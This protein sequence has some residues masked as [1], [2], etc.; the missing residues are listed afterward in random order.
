MARF[1]FCRYIS[2]TQLCSV[3][4]LVKLT[5][6]LQKINSSY[7][8]STAAKSEHTMLFCRKYKSKPH[9]AILATTNRKVAGGKL[10][11]F[12]AQ[13]GVRGGRDHRKHREAEVPTGW[14]RKLAARS[15]RHSHGSRKGDCSEK[16]QPVHRPRQVH[17]CPHEIPDRDQA[18]R[19]PVTAS[20]E[21]A[22]GAISLGRK[23]TFICAFEI[24]QNNWKLTARKFTFVSFLDLFRA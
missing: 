22:T 11:I 13:V 23:I 3:Q 14:V 10:C 24:R 1:Y 6:M 17:D 9:E 15:R 20:R 19:L 21:G 7:D 12:R 16:Q 18:F 5:A 4:N 8:A 2:R